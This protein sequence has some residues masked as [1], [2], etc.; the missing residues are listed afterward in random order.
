MVGKVVK[1]PAFGNGDTLGD[2]GIYGV[3]GLVF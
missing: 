3:E 1:A 2:D